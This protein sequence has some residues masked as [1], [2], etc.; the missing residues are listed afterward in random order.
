MPTYQE[1][2]DLCYNKCDWIWTTTN[3]VNGYIVRGRGGYASSSIFLPA[4]GGSSDRTLF[5]VGSLGTY[6]SSIP[7]SD[8][9]GSW[10]IDFT[11]SYHDTLDSG[12]FSG[13][14]IRPVQSPAE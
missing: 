8:G 2:N 7:D 10:S 6:L 1:L 11:F 12:R 9:N 5:F 3:G 4:A 14:S 13:F